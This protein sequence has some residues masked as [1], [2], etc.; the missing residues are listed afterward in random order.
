MYVSG[1]IRF[2]IPDGWL[3]WGWKS[4]MMTVAAEPNNAGSGLTDRHERETEVEM[5]CK[6]VKSSRVGIATVKSGDIYSRIIY[7]WMG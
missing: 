3:M 6:N 4:R 7:S 1:G 2:Q 5:V